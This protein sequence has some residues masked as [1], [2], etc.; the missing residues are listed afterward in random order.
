MIVDDQDRRSWLHGFSLAPRAPAVIRANPDRSSVLA[1]TGNS[2]GCGPI[3]PAARIPNVGLA[4][5][6]RYPGSERKDADM[7]GT[8]KIP[9]GSCRRPLLVAGIGLAMAELRRRRRHGV[10]AGPARRHLL[11]SH[12]CGAGGRHKL[13]R[14]DQPDVDQQRFRRG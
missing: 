9:G 3:R 10:P 7:N 8:R 2:G 11:G 13:A 4:G 12:S 1:R 14:Q 5:G 6:I